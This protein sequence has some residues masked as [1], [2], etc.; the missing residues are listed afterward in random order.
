MA[1][2][3]FF[4]IPPEWR[5]QNH[6]ES[7]FH[8]YNCNMHPITWWQQQKKYTKNTHTKS[9][10][11]A[12]F[13]CFETTTTRSHKFVYTK[14]NDVTEFLFTLKVFGKQC[15][16]NGFFAVSLLSFC[17]FGSEKKESCSLPSCK[18]SL[19]VAIIFVSLTADARF[20]IELN[21]HHTFSGTRNAILQ[22]FSIIQY[23]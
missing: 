13:M 5:M 6:T 21:K 10:N 7:N 15:L 12:R 18:Y 1:I 16:P 19:H 8:L 3:I 22:W 9:T 2:N 11:Y 23:R 20:L 4:G 17:H 14:I